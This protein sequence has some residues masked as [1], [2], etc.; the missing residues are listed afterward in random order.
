[1]MVSNKKNKLIDNGTTDHCYRESTEKTIST[2]NQTERKIFISVKGDYKI[3]E[4]NQN[5]PILFK[6]DTI[7]RES[8]IKC[9]ANSKNDKVMLV[10]SL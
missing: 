3:V 2:F 4:L 9:N 7:K 8:E 10:A 6:Y 5:K 1:M